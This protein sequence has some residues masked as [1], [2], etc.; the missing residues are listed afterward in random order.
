[1]PDAE[2]S[3]KTHRLARWWREWWQARRTLAQLDSC[4]AAEVGHIAHDIGVS[5]GDLRVL[6][7]KWPEAADLLVRRM[8]EIRLDPTDVAQVEPGVVRDLQRVCT[9]CVSKRKCVHDLATKPTD[10]AWQD[11]C[12]NAMTLKALIAERANSRNAKAS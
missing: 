11:Y 8:T 2:N 12:P 6:A 7:G 9:L 3:P 4:G 1:M 10:P 5:S